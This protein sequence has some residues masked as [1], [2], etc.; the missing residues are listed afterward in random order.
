MFENCHNEITHFVQVLRRV[1][2]KTVN[3]RFWEMKF[4]DENPKP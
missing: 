3:D 4:R 1:R 2:A